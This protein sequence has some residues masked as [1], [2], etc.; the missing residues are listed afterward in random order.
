MRVSG[1]NRA[2]GLEYNNVKESSL[3]EH[4]VHGRVAGNPR[5]Q[6]LEAVKV[7]FAVA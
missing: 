5:T 4:G 2:Q 6:G 3:P 7:G 1:N